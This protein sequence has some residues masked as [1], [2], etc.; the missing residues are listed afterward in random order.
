MRAP[1]PVFRDTLKRHLHLLVTLK[2]P[3]WQ[4]RLA[5]EMLA[6]WIDHPDCE[7]IWATIDTSLKVKVTPDRF[8]GDVVT[9]RLVSETLVKIKKSDPKAEMLACTEQ[10]IPRGKLS[11]LGDRFAD[12]ATTLPD[13][14]RSRVRARRAGLLTRKDTA[15]MYFSRTLSAGFVRWSKDEQPHDD[16]VRLLINIAFDC[17]TTTEAVRA[18]RN[19]AIRTPKN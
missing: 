16:T 12:F 4:R 18:A 6:R 1:A 9:T 8:I 7:S 17:E 19:R 2:P 14:E 10:L 11:D 3:S 15:R 5:E 13:F